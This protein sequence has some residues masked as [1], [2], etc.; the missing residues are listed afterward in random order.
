MFDFITRLLQHDAERITGPPA[1]VS[2]VSPSNG[3][4]NIQLDQVITWGRAS[5]ARWYDV[6]LDTVNPPTTKVSDN[7]A[8]RAYVPTLALDTTYYLRIN[9]GNKY[10]ETTGD[11]VSFSTWASAELVMS[12][13]GTT[14]AI[15]EDGNYVESPDV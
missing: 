14:P 11:V 7:Q 10:G 8:A 15:D 5:M 13:D 3:A 1:K 9:S 6:Y 2:G 12:D 4:V